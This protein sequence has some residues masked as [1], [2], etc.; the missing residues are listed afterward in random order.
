MPHSPIQINNLS[1]VLPYK[2]NFEDFNFQ[3][4]SNDKITIIGRNGSGKSSFLIMLFKLLQED[5]INVSYVPQHIEKSNLSGGES[6]NKALTKALS[7][8]PDILLL[9]EP[10]NHLDIK[11]RKSLIRMLLNYQGT[12]IFASHDEE[13][14][15]NCAN[16]LLIIENN[17]INVFN[18][19]YGDY[20]IEKQIKIQKL[21]KEMKALNLQKE[22]LSCKLEKEKQ[23]L[24][25]S[26]SKGEKKIANRNVDKITGNFNMM[27]A[28]KS[29]GKKL[30][31]I[32]SSKED[33]FQK[34]NSFEISEVIMPKFALPSHGFQNKILIE[35]NNGCIGYSEE[36]MILKGINLTVL[37]N[38]RVCIKGGNGKGKTTLIKAIMGFESVCKKGDWNCL[39][40]EDIGYLSQTYETLE[41]GKTVFQEVADTTL[42]LSTS[43]IRNHLNSFLFR[44]NEEVNC[45]VKNLSGGEKAR[46]SLAKIALKTPKLLILDEI[47]N[48]LDIE[49]KE[50][51][52][53]ILQKYL[54]A[55]IIISH[56]IDFLNA[57]KIDNLFDVDIINTNR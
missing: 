31:F 7:K 25:K 47:T 35:I 54:G 39:K 27:N 46:L 8:T 21:E 53:Q 51:V 1:L 52:I 29:S 36:N 23:K 14:I 45:D 3:I 57:I 38:Q 41:E 26:K 30:G 15:R 24:S 49:T 34:L 32:K 4:N 40:I 22:E 50:H 6:F 9:D 42:N 5:D 33:V 19:S 28:E 17:K 20:K 13:L 12:L 16:T 56:D 48:N 55:V 2:T 43:E 18:G 11:N 10:T 44:K 37:G